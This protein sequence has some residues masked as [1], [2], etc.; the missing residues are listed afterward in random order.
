[1]GTRI[2]KLMARSA[3]SA[4]VLVGLLAPLT[5]AA[6]GRTAVAG[7]SARL[8]VEEDGIQRVTYESLRAAG[9]DLA[10]VN[11]KQIGVRDG[12]HAVPVFV[13][14]GGKFGPGS[15]IE[16][17]GQG[18]DTSL[19]QP[20]RI[21]LLGTGFPMGPN[22]LDLPA[23]GIS[24]A[25]SRATIDDEETVHRTLAAQNA[26]SE[27][28]SSGDPWFDAEIRAISSPA[29]VIRTLS[30][31]G[32]LAGGQATL[33]VDVWGGITWSGAA[34]DHHVEVLLNGQ[35]VTD[36]H[37]D[38][39]ESRVL[40][41]RFPS[42]R[43]IDGAN[44]VTVRLPRDTG[45]SADIVYLEAIHLSYPGPRRAHEGRWSG[46]VSLARGQGASVAIGG[47]K[48][49]S[50][51][52]WAAMDNGRV[53][54]SVLTSI[55]GRVVLPLRSGDWSFWLSGADNIAQ[56]GILAG[57]APVAV[58]TRVDYLILTHG[59]LIGSELLALADL[60]RSKGLSTAVVDVESIYAAYSSYATDAHA[61][62]RYVKA[63]SPRYLLLVGDDSYDYKGYSGPAHRQRVPTHYIALDDMTQYSPSDALYGDLNG[64]HIAD[65][66][67][68]RLPVSSR[69]EIAG[70]V[71]RLRTGATSPQ[72]ATFASGKSDIGRV[73]SAGSEILAEAYGRA[74]D[75]ISADHA[76]TA[77]SRDALLDAL[78]LGPG[79]ISY[80]GHSVIEGWG[81]DNFLRNADVQ[82]MPNGT[83]AGIVSNWTSWN[84]YFVHPTR[85]S[86]GETFLTTPGKGALVSIGSATTSDIYVQ[87]AIG[88]RF[89][90][91]LGLPGHDTVGDA[92]LAATREAVAHDPGY[93]KSHALSV[94]Y[95]GDPAVTTA[96]PTE[97]SPPE[98]P[99]EPPGGGTPTR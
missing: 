32:R 36:G 67:V 87:Q 71:A 10:G 27:F 6:I 34:P 15:W 42:E 81:F 12:Q 2:P 92:W 70:Y 52:G 11:S 4:L 16:F 96:L 59:G 74:H 72:W 55:N 23:G 84:N 89:L 43:L 66:P 73:F 88:A 44:T 17:I 21:Y 14:G 62:G 33:E 18:D 51:L 9:V 75:T 64:D 79:L 76:G 61:I 39:L 80:H 31:V 99:D 25:A 93:L 8:V 47:F 90:S 19:Y 82:A 56:P 48:N 49:G 60:Q 40:V 7:V 26:Y 69:A 77:A 45:Y 37:F 35:L 5:A 20:G 97:Q 54:R 91:K 83:Y 30:A 94:M 78:R 86:I 57:A 13:G 53:I 28:S 3:V 46:E 65:I 98:E 68:G 41:A 95:F 63:V 50:V 38:G 29:E 58:P 1:M 24:M 22:V 85:R